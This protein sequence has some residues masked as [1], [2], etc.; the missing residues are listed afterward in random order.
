[1]RNRTSTADSPFDVIVIGVGGIGAAA[2]YH[3]ARRGR[4]VLVLEQFQIGNNYGSSHGE[5]RIIRYTHDNTDYARFMPQTF[6]LWRN[7][8][9]ESNTVLLQDTGSLFVGS[10]DNE[11]LRRCRRTLDT[12]SFP[13]DHVNGTELIAAFPRFRFPE[14]WIGL[15]QP[16]AGILAA[17]RCVHTLASQ[18]LKYGA[19]LQERTRVQSVTPT[20]DGVVVH[21]TSPE[22]PRTFHAEQAIIAAGA[23]APVFFRALLPVPVPLRV[24]HQQVAYFA[25]EH[26]E[27]FAPDRFPVFIIDREP[28][29]YGFPVWER[30]G[31]VKIAVEQSEKTVN[32]D[33][34][35]QLDQDLLQELVTHVKTVLPDVIPE[36]IAAQPCL[37]TETA[38]R[39]FIVDR[40]P[41]FPQILFAAGFSGRGFKHTIAIG[42][43]LA[44]LAGTS[45]GVYDSPFWLDRFRIDRF[46]SPACPV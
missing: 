10:D 32:P 16:N 45:A 31:A 11:F 20:G 9:R 19:Q 8:E 21:A 34:E 25:V 6:E 4:R 44:D 2:A 22:G 35:R 13:Y 14:G 5:S 36:P 18:A 17:A 37:Y 7:L 15:F 3:L 46:Y 40:H 23:W 28:H 43:L 27:D 30:P 39:D 41:D 38:N 33:E 1:M 24:T 29:C 12:L 26:P 42:H